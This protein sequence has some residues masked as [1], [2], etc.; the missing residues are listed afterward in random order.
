MLQPRRILPLFCAL[1]FAATGCAPLVGHDTS[2]RTAP[3]NGDRFAR[4]WCEAQT[5]DEA[6]FSC[7]SS[8]GR[9]V[10][11]GDS[12]FCISPSGTAATGRIVSRSDETVVSAPSRAFL[13]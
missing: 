12:C 3:P 13:K 5:R 9:T 10:L 1:A 2:A 6:A 8:R 7:G 11:P 4:V